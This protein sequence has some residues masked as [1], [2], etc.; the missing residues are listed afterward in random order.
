MCVHR[1]VGRLVGDAALYNAAAGLVMARY[2]IPTH[3]QGTPHTFAMQEAFMKPGDVHFKYQGY[4]ALAKGVAEV[5]LGAITITTTTATTALAIEAIS[6]PE[7]VPEAATLDCNIMNTKGLPAK[8]LCLAT[9]PYKANC[10]FRST[11]THPTG[12]CV[13]KGLQPDNG[14]SC[15]VRNKQG[16]P[17]RTV[18]LSKEPYKTMCTWQRTVVFPSGQCAHI[19]TTPAGVTSHSVPT[20]VATGACQPCAVDV[21]L[22]FTEG[23]RGHRAVTVEH[24]FLGEIRNDARVATANM[25]AHA[26]VTRQTP[27]FSFQWRKKDA[28]NWVCSLFGTRRF[29]ALSQEWVWQTAYRFYNRLGCGDC[30]D[31]AGGGA[32]TVGHPGTTRAPDKC[33]VRNKAGDPAQQLCR[34]RQPYTREC[35]WSATPGFPAGQCV[36]KDLSESPDA[37]TPS[38]EETCD[39]R[40]KAGNP[41]KQLCYTQEPYKTSCRWKPTADFPLGQCIVRNGAPDTPLAPV[42]TVAANCDIRNKAGNP[43]KQTCLTRA[44]YKNSCVWKPTVAFPA[45]QCISQQQDGLPDPFADGVQGSVQLNCDARNRAG[46]PAKLNCL[47]KEPY[48]SNCRWAPSTDFPAGQ[49]QPAAAPKQL[50]YAAGDSSSAHSAAGTGV[51]GNGKRP[52]NV[53]TLRNPVVVTTLCI[54]LVAI[55]V[56]PLLVH[57]AFKR[58]RA[59]PLE[60]PGATS[61]TSSATGSKVSF[62]TSIDS[63]HSRRRPMNPEPA[64]VN[65]SVSE[66]PAKFASDAVLLLAAVQRTP[67]SHGHGPALEE[68]VPITVIDT[69]LGIHGVAQPGIIG[70]SALHVQAATLRATRA[71][72][73]PHYTNAA[74]MY[75]NLEH[76]HGVTSGSDTVPACHEEDL[77][78]ATT[79][80]TNGRPMSLFEMTIIEWGDGGDLPQ[81]ICI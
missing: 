10:E 41:A 36:A 4:A 62:A 3:D 21:L 45:G 32:R 31:G 2:G 5:I 56:V 58:K 1:A 74:P 12:Q 78:I 35:K 53:F 71:S 7:R 67:S 59:V 66:V 60:F 28:G 79:A 9:Q 48:K 22:G 54:L 42:S 40:N 76:A 61:E 65:V 57:A 46:L 80:A 19:E 64:N 33:D 50:G 72:S 68:P 77:A 16:L 18:C 20:S 38:A 6:M 27:C 55:V 25:C 51:I 70:S 11:L 29:S 37:R 47:T 14:A 13:T 34:T 17:A 39:V 73:A 24:D 81:G 26:C 44:P 49:C 43:A 30:R 15:D 75:D 8:Q 52:P 63:T 69:A 23:V